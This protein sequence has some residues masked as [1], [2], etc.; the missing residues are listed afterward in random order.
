[1]TD[2]PTASEKP[3]SCSRANRWILS[4]DTNTVLPL[5][6]VDLHNHQQIQRLLRRQLQPLSLPARQSSLALAPA[7]PSSSPRKPGTSTTCPSTRRATRPC[8]LRSRCLCPLA[9]RASNDPLDKL[10]LLTG[11]R[12]HAATR[13]MRRQHHPPSLRANLAPLPLHGAHST[14]KYTRDAK[15]IQMHHFKLD[16]AGA[17]AKAGG[18]SITSGSSVVTIPADPTQP[19]LVRSVS[20]TS[21]QWRAA[22]WPFKRRHGNRHRCG[23]ASD[24]NQSSTPVFCRRSL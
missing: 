5:L 15:T 14:I 24:A 13:R 19:A 6:E 22:R 21:R 17:D 23:R 3:A 18:M 10:P 4:R 12:H 2:S 7:G 16:I 1:M 20:R 11:S 9:F 8:N